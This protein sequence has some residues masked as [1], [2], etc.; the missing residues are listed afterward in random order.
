M[1]RSSPEGRTAAACALA[2]LLAHSDANKTVA[3]EKPGV[4]AALVAFVGA[5]SGT[6][7]ALDRPADKDAGIAARALLNLAS[8]KNAAAAIAG[9]QG[10]TDA[11]AALVLRGKAET[12]EDAAHALSLMVAQSKEVALAVANCEAAVHALRSAARATNCTGETRLWCV[13]ALH[14]ISRCSRARVTLLRAKVI[15]DV[16]LPLL[17]ADGA[18]ALGEWAE[19]VQALA[20]MAVAN[21][22]GWLD[23]CALTAHKEHVAG[24]VHVMATAITAREHGRLRFR[25]AH[26]LQALWSLAP[27]DTFKGDLVGAKLLELSIDM[28][29]LAHTQGNRGVNLVMLLEIIYH[30]C[31]LPAG[32][33]RFREL[34]GTRVLETHAKGPD[35]LVR[36]LARGALWQ[37]GV[38]ESAAEGEARGGPH[39]YLSFAEEDRARAGA[40]AAALQ[41]E[42]YGLVLTGERRRDG[43]KQTHLVGMARGMQGAAAVVVCISTSYCASALCRTEAEYAA[44]I[45]AAVV[46]LLLDDSRPA[47]HLG[48][49]ASTLDCI[50][51]S[52]E[53]ALDL[54]VMELA[55]ELGERGKAAPEVGAASPSTVP[56]SKA[57]STPAA[58]SISPETPMLAAGRGVSPLPT[59]EMTHAVSAGG[60]AG[61]AGAGAS[62]GRGGG[63]FSGLLGIG[64]P[65]GAEAEAGCAGGA[66]SLAELERV[67]GRAVRLHQ[68]RADAR[69]SALETEVRALR[70]QVA[71]LVAAQGGQGHGGGGGEGAATW[72]DGAGS[73]EGTG[74]I[75]GE[76]NA[77]GASSAAGAAAVQGAGVVQEQGANEVGGSGGECSGEGH[78]DAA[79]QEEAGS[80][81][82]GGASQDS[83][84]AG[85]LTGAERGANGAFA[86]GDTRGRRGKGRGRRSGAG[87]LGDEA[88]ATA[89]LGATIEKLLAAPADGP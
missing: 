81:V 87:K 34:E 58:G 69:V 29:A 84:G 42:G 35:P 44:E 38:R 88:V 60:S 2:N 86:E 16:F 24:L 25:N 10:A 47:K 51:A 78:A 21:L 68:A 82:E 56:A 20:T 53:G 50:D 15:D 27:N 33:A 11:L 65:G 71:A 64:G 13:S 32:A 46:P 36:K 19:A 23:A 26:V 18:L 85:C 9:A 54:A 6:A 40:V 66:V 62:G 39:L 4:L 7:G 63:L 22:T 14:A 45:D 28:V 49:I 48:G 76:S 74:R 70:A 72:L 5:T 75:A 3:A 17:A 73:A 80:E 83:E 12:K 89:E 8:N 31:F 79:A 43:K 30:L 55:N 59:V 77:E 52:D 1:G 37:M 57:P 61:G 67:V 41:K